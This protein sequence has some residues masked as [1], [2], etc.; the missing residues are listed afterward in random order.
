MQNTWVFQ[1]EFYLAAFATYL[2]SVYK[3]EQ[4]R[5]PHPEL[6]SCIVLTWPRVKSLQAMDEAALLQRSWFGEVGGLASGNRATPELKSVCEE[7]LIGRGLT[8]GAT[9]EFAQ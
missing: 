3:A 6:C 9:E 5:L 4:Y 7:A 8:N 1:G 2:K